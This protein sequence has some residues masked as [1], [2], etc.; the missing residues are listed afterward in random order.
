MMSRI[1]ASTTLATV[2]GG[3]GMGI[4]TTGAGATGG[5]GTSATTAGAAGGIGTTGV[6]VDLRRRHRPSCVLDFVLLWISGF[7]FWPAE[8]T[9]CWPSSTATA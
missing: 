4:G 1:V 6:A 2:A 7:H 8:S 9:S 5:S 3:I